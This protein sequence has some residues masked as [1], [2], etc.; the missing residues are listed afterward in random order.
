MMPEAWASSRVMATGGGRRSLR[1]VSPGRHATLY[2]TQF[3][4]FGVVIPFLPAVLAARGLDAEEVAAVLAAG[5]AVRLLAG[6]LGGR[7]ADALGTPRG[8]I[9]FAAAM[10]ALAALGFSALA[11]FAWL[12]AAHILLSAAMAPVVPLTDAVVVAAAREGRF[13]YGRVRAWGSIAF[14]AAALQGGQA[15]ERVG[16]DGALALI[17][18]GLGVT[19]AVAMLLPAA[20]RVPRRPSGSFT[21][22]LRVPAFRWLLLVSA[23][24]SASHAFY[25]AF[26]T[27]HWQAAGLGAGLIGALWAT[28]VV[29]EIALF[30]WGRDVVA[31]LG[32]VR[33]GVIAA[34]AGA[35]RWAA[36]AFTTDPAIL[37][38]IQ[39][40]HAGSF[41][42]QHL[43]TMMILARVVPAEQAGTAQTVH[44]SLG[45]GLAM[46]GV[47]ALCGP[48]YAAA[49]GAGYLAMAAL[50]A[51]AV[52]ASLALGKALSAR[53]AER[54]GLETV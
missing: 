51:A 18:L 52:P 20:P 40:L 8:V 50:C 4:A 17:A 53:G 19:S 43:A 32:P 46:G 23:L 9:A 27:L 30:L 14:I 45:P 26:G 11:G 16:P 25:Y 28:G 44:A 6:P 5:S 15:V 54:D 21:A 3:F 10:G 22:P 13:D 7:A 37:F 31:R 1:L 38:P 33:L 47:T 34:V 29:A 12:M 42:A 2:A 24:M 48:L 36:T 39:V 41:G 35:V 49:G